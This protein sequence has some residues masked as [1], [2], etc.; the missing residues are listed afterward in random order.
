M[1]TLKLPSQSLSNEAAQVSIVGPGSV[2]GGDGGA[3]GYSAGAGGAGTVYVTLRAGLEDQTGWRYAPPPPSGESFGSKKK[4]TVTFSD[5]G[6]LLYTDDDQFF[7]GK[8]PSLYVIPTRVGYRFAG[9]WTSRDEGN[10]CFYDRNN[11][12]MLP[13]VDQLDEIKLE[14]RWEPDPSALVVTSGR[15]YADGADRGDDSGVTLRDA[16]KTLCDNPMLTGTNGARRITFALPKD[17]CTVRLTQ[18]IIVPAGTAP[19]EVFGLCGDEEDAWAVT[20]DG[21]GKTRLFDLRGDGVTFSHLMFTGGHPSEL[22]GGAIRCDNSSV[23]ASDCSFFGNFA[24][25]GAAV[26]SKNGLVL[27]RNCTFAGNAASFRYGAVSASGLAVVLN[28]TFSENVASGSGSSAAALG[29]VGDGL[30]A[31]CTFARNG[32]S[33]AVVNLPDTDTAVTAVNCIFADGAEAVYARDSRTLRMLYSGAAEPSAAFAGKGLPLTNDTEG[34]NIYGVRHVWYEPRQSDANFDAAL[35]YYDGYSGES[36]IAV[37]GVETNV[38]FGT[39]ANATIPILADQLRCARLA[40][41]RGAIRILSGEDRPG[42]TLEGRYVANKNAKKTFQAKVRY[43]DLENEVTSD[44]S[45]TTDKDGFFS[46]K[47]PVDGSDGTAH[48]AVSCRIEGLNVGDERMSIATLPYAFTASSAT[49]LLTDD[50][51]GE[52]RDQQHA[53][54]FAQELE[55]AALEAAHVVEVDEEVVE[56]GLEAAHADAPH[57]NAR[58][59]RHGAAA[60]AA[61]VLDSRKFHAGYY[62]IRVRL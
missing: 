12:P 55:R 13:Y 37:K 9:W 61:D 17:N 42:V 16:V 47:I 53:G 41:A 46:A 62:T 20:V 3:G 31:H 7:M 43:D 56:R 48:N 28:C 27:L 51:Q 33:L 30:V 57:E 36:A 22:S 24:S 58:E 59:E 8:L 32:K 18:P 15:D 11:K 26:Y 39:A 6:T 1:M 54:R 44:I 45:V 21:G 29:L 19:F 60:G 5:R 10:V 35:I 38:L 14:A 52:N 25:E 23:D 50:Q 49:A 4:V 40:P 34:V 2:T